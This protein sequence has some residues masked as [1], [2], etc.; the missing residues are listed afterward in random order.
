[1]KVV[2]LFECY[3]PDTMNWAYELIRHVRDTENAIASPWLLNNQYV[4]AEFQ[5]VK[6]FWQRRPGHPDSDSGFR[7]LVARTYEKLLPLDR[8]RI[9]SFCQEWKPDLLHAHF[10]PVGCQYLSMANSLEIPLVVSFYGYDLGHVLYKKPWWKEKYSKLF[11]GAAALVTTGPVTANMLIEL[12]CPSHKIHPVP[13]GFVPD[14]F[15]EIPRHKSAGQLKMV[16][17]STITRKK[18]HLDTLKALSAVVSQCPGIHLTLVGDVQDRTLAEEMRKLILKCKLEQHVSW[19][20]AVPHERLAAILSGFDVFIQPSN[21]TA[22]RDN[23]GSPVVFLEAQST[24]MPVIST[25]HADIPYIVQHGRTGLL[26]SEHDVT[27]IAGAM[28]RFY[29]MEDA[30]YQAFRSSAARFVR[31]R[32]TVEKSAAL[33]NTVYQNLLKA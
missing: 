29:R 18:G 23:E 10:G 32:F 5:Y 25:L 2:H 33:L 16:Q 7:H 8:Y 6:P 14:L 15:P 28:E 26:S 31:D 27:G 11:S 30:E 21:T 17:V 3:L 4:S 9:K 19:L 20:P 13:P 12:G 22:Q 1:M 24:G